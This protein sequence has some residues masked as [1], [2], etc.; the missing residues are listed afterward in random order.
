VIPKGEIEYLDALVRGVYA[1]KSL[2][3][4]YQF[5]HET[6]DEDFYLAIPLLKGQ[7][8][9]REVLTGL[10]LVEPLVSDAPL[11]ISAVDGPY[12]KGTALGAMIENRGLSA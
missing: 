5:N 1:R 4:G 7:L 3:A 6:F 9:V 10:T 12:G 11:T 8:S 2:P